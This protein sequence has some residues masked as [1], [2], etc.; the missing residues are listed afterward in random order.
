MVLQ[1]ECIVRK[2]S[3]FPTCQLALKV[4][5]F[6]F[7]CLDGQCLDLNGSGRGRVDGFQQ[8]LQMSFPGFDRVR[9]ARGVLGS[10]GH[11]YYSVVTPGGSSVQPADV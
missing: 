8:G 1:I 5:Q 9:P 6:R 7:D 2:F 3:L 10:L 11:C 4:G